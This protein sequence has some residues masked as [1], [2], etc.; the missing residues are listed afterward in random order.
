MVDAKAVAKQTRPPPRFTDATLLTAME[1]AGRALP[2]K[3]LADAMRECGLGTPAT[4]AAI[5]EVLLKREYAARDGKSLAGDRQGHRP[6]RR[7]PR[8]REEPRDDRRVGGEARAHRA[9]HGRLRRVHGGHRGLRARGGRE[10]PRRRAAGP[11]GP[12]EGL[13][14]RVAASR[15]PGGPGERPRAG[16]REPAPERARE[17]EARRSAPERALAASPV[18]RVAA[19]AAAPRRPPSSPDALVSLLQREVRLRVVQAVPGRG[20][21]RG[22][23]RARRAARD[24][25]R[26]G[27]VPLLPAPRPGARRHDARRE[28]AHRAD[29]GSGRAS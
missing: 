23:A 18:A 11:G 14:P 13:E 5:L 22:D 17:L 28:P 24:A 8:E 7:R 12:R 3:E 6:H 26:R 25:H 9:R 29:G 19:P 10:R 15:G 4:R 27:Q 1:T 2:E 16:A 20:V 21:P